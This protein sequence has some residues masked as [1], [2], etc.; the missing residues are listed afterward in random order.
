MISS[1]AH[2]VQRASRRNAIVK[3]TWTCRAVEMG[4]CASATGERAT[5]VCIGSAGHIL[6]RRLRP[7]CRAHSRCEAGNAQRLVAASKQGCDP[8]IERGPAAEREQIAAD[9]S[10]PRRRGAAAIRTS[11]P[12]CPT[13]RRFRARYWSLVPPSKQSSSAGGL[14]LARDA[15]S[16]PGVQGGPRDW[17]G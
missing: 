3:E 2:A 9:R 4:E 11:A 6:R 15:T 7:A 12:R 17:R 13:H 1:N 8:L 14:A 5:R 16:V 10:L